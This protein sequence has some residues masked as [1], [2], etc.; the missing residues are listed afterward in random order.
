MI[1][2]AIIWS[3]YNRYSKRIFSIMAQ[4]TTKDKHFIGEIGVLIINLSN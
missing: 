3:Q 2:L 1:L 4:H